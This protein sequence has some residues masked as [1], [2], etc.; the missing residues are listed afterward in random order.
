MYAKYDAESKICYPL[1]IIIWTKCES[2]LMHH[3]PFHESRYLF[4][5]LKEQVLMGTLWR[6]ILKI[7]WVYFVSVLF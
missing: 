2:I 7:T 3:I 5:A 6:L 1:I 4:Q